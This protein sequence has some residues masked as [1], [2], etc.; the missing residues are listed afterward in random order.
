MTFFRPFTAKST[1]IFSVCLLLRQTP[2]LLKAVVGAKFLFA[3]KTSNLTGIVGLDR[4]YLK[5]RKHAR[6]AQ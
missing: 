5:E 3:R 4:K 6:K 1:Y 2:L